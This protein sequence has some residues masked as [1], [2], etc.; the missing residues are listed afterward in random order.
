M[1][2]LKDIEKI[3][4]TG[5]WRADAEA[6]RLEV[7]VAMGDGSLV[8]SDIS[9]TALSHWAL[10]AVRRRNPGKTPALYSPGQDSTEELEIAEPAMIEAIERIRSAIERTRPHPGRLRYITLALV[11]AVLALLAVF[12]VPNALRDH[13]LRVLPQPQRLAIGAAMLDRITTLTG[14]ACAAPRSQAALSALSERVLPGADARLVVLPNLPKPTMHLPGPYIV[15]SADLLDP[16]LSPEAVAGHILVAFLRTQRHDS[17]ES[18][19]DF[20]GFQETFRLLTR[21]DTHPDT[22]RSYVN[23]RL[24]QPA[25][26]IPND[27]TIAFFDRMRVPTTPYAMTLDPAAQAVTALADG[28]PYGAQPAPAVL[29]DTAWLA[30]TNIC[31]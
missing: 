31:Q 24:T 25:E 12:W 19:L 28:D 7:F 9:E 16:A 3:E 10:A 13:T 18:Y 20:A 6:Q 1:T 4:T 22:V 14:P 5:L 11:T 17:L 30:L 2:A 23:L 27:T 15:I 26:A 8:I 29:S 21:G